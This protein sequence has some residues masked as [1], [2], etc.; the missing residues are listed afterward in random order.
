MT[1]YTQRH[2]VTNIPMIFPTNISPT[3]I[4]FKTF[5]D[6]I[7]TALDTMISF[8]VSLDYPTMMNSIRSFIA[9][10]KII[11]LGSVAE[12]IAL[13]GTVLSGLTRVEDKFLFASSTLDNRIF[14][15]AFIST[16]NRAGEDA[17]RST[18]RYIE[19]F[20][21]SATKCESHN[22]FHYNT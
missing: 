2:I 10:P 15:T 12:A 16:L 7:Q 21:A 5:R 14:P 18:R 22:L 1:L 8:S 3:K 6:F 9:L 13:Y 20:F 19:G 17:M 11:F 4:S